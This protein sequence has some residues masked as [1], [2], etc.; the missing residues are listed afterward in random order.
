MNHLD[1]NIKKGDWTRKEDETILAL[2]GAIGNRWCKFTE[3]LPGRTDC[4]I[5][6]RYHVLIRKNVSHTGVSPVREVQASSSMDSNYSYR[7]PSAR[8]RPQ[9]G[10]GAISRPGGAQEGSHAMSNLPVSSAPPARHVAR[11]EEENYQSDSARPPGSRMPM[12][13][14]SRPP[15]LTM[16]EP[17]LIEIP[18]V[19]PSRNE[20][21]ADQEM[22]ELCTSPNVTSAETDP[23]HTANVNSKWLS[24]MNMHQAALYSMQ[25]PNAD[26]MTGRASYLHSNSFDMQLRDFSPTRMNRSYALPSN[27]PA[28]P[29]SLSSSGWYTFS[30]SAFSNVFAQPLTP[31]IC[32]YEPPSSYAPKTKK[33]KLLQFASPRDRPQSPPSMDLG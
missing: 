25:S 19:D 32:A 17:L 30:P 1:P 6:N 4:A 2:H 12:D 15:V 23:T 27:S 3:H 18:P 7:D 14:M 8:P 11:V 16:S 22:L 9:F 31:M 20:T 10:Q 24:Q 28:A 33:Q 5:K 29:S 26:P 21:P 13:G